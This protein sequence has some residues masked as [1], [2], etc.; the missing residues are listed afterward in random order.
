MVAN[1]GAMSH[2]VRAA[3]APATRHLYAAAWECFRAFAERAGHD[4]LCAD[5]EL[6]VRYID[7]AGESRTPAT[8]RVHISAIAAAYNEAGR[9]SPTKSDLVKRALAGHRK[10]LGRAARQAAPLDKEAFGHV[11]ETAHRPRPTRGGRLE[12]VQEAGARALLDCALIGLMRD[13]MLRRSE[14]AALTWADLSVERDGSGRVWIH[15]SKTD[16][17]AEGAMCYVSPEVLEVLE[18]LRVTSEAGSS[19]PIIGLSPSQ[20]CR[21]IQAACTAAGLTG[22]YSGHSPRIGMATDLARDGIAMPLILKAGRWKSERTVMRYVEALEV[23]RGAVAQWY[24]QQPLD[25]DK[26]VH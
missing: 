8:L 19:D 24:A 16:Q 25:D 26:E 12:T 21:R 4:P 3:R 11:C 6:V 5:A 18:V 2:N 10:R 23:G 13:A 9:G 17:E 1:A 20:I 22:E 14:V 15:R 7:E